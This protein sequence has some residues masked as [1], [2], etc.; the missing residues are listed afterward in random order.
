MGTSKQTKYDKVRQ[1]LLDGN[2]ISSIEA[3]NLF[4]VTRLSAI[5][6]TM[7]HRDNIRIDSKT[8]QSADGA[9]YSRYWVNKDYLE[10]DRRV[11]ND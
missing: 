9:Y 3:F 6:H 11:D 4:K 7:R 2:T 10:Q 1:H 5:I 8:E